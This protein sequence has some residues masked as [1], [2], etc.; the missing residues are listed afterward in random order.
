MLASKGIY[1]SA[2]SACRSLES[3]P[4][5]VLTAMGLTPDEAR[6]S[7]RVSFSTMNGLWEMDA[8]ARE[9]ADCVEFLYRQFEN[10]SQRG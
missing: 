7:V 5:H 3:E 10:N 4:S 9:M 6:D 2:G 8:A 1:L